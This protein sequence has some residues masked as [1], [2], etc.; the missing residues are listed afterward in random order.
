MKKK[1]IQMTFSITSVQ[2]RCCIDSNHKMDSD[3]TNAMRFKT[4]PLSQRYFN[5]VILINLFLNIERQ[6][7]VCLCMLVTN[8]DIHID[9][10]MNGCIFVYLFVLR[11]RFFFKEKRETE[12]KQSGGEDRK[13]TEYKRT[14]IL[15]NFNFITSLINYTVCIESVWFGLGDCS[16]FKRY[17]YKSM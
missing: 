5:K 3:D 2:K 11:A 10:C 14:V 15:F 1:T 13:K 4:E 8:Q 9:E 6:F 7:C 17:K 16:C 12:V